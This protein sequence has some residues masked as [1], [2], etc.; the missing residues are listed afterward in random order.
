MAAVFNDTYGLGCSVPT[1]YRFQAS[2]DNCTFDFIHAHHD[3][4]FDWAQNMV[5]LRQNWAA[6]VFSN[7]NKI[8]LDPVTRIYYI[9]ETCAFILGRIC[10]ATLVAAQR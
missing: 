5:N 8:N 10:R 1:V 4:R 2:V 3:T 6:T 9:G 7:E